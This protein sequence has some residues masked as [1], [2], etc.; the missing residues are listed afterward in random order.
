VPELRFAYDTGV[1][2]RDRVEE[3]LAEIRDEAEKPPK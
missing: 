3:L 2:A 1:D